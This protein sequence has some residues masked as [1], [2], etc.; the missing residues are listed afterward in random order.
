MYILL[1]GPPGAGKGTQAEKLIREYG[2]PQIST[3]DMFRAAVKSGTALGKEAKSYMDKGALVPDSVTVG[4]V[5]ERL[6]QDDC[7]KGWILDG[8]PRTTAQASALDAILHDLGIQ[9]TAVLDFNVN[10][11][12]LVKRVSGRLVCRQ[13]GASFHKEF[14]PP[15]QEGVCDNCGGELYQRADDNEVTVRERLAVYDTST[16]PLIDYYKVSGR[17]YEINGDQSM[18]KVFAD[19]QAAL[20]KA[21]E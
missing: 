20:K 15:K 1:M 17:Y 5:K 10:R 8:F 4:I 7:K 6:A 18:D 16:K 19:V 12:D 3:G 13:C 21:S 2:I 9:L 14:R 11:D